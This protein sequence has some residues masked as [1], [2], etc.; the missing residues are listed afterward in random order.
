M[1]RSTRPANPGDMVRSLAVILVPLLIITVLFTRN[2]DDHPVTVVDVT[3]SLTAARQQAPYPVLAPVNLPPQWRPIRV[4]WEKLGR[5]ALNGERSVR[6]A[7]RLGYL[8]PEGVYVALDQGDRLP[9]DLVATA[10]RDGTPDGQSTVGADTWERRVSL[11][12]RTRALVLRRPEVTSVVSGD[13]GYGEL[14]AFAGS[15]RDR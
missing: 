8:D 7:W 5:P 11:D 10:S 15:L 14:E 6:N 9:E 13:T 2:P 12:G 3:P 4:S 1:A